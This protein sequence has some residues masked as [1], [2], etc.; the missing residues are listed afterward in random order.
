[1][2]K[3]WVARSMQIA[4]IANERLIAGLN[5]TEVLE[6][7]H[8][9]EIKLKHLIPNYNIQEILHIKSIKYLHEIPDDDLEAQERH[10]K[11]VEGDLIA[12]GIKFDRNI[13]DDMDYIDDI[14]SLDWHV[15]KNHDKINW[16]FQGGS[17]GKKS[18]ILSRLKKE[19]DSPPF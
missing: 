8:K 3:E 2:I 18:G 17:S 15:F 6:R 1:M 5:P 16:K 13:K 7:L 19:E 10:Q 4:C 14:H 11:R 9:R 12:A